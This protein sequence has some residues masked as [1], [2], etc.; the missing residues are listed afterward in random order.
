MKLSAEFILVKTKENVTKNNGI[1]M[2]LSAYILAKL[3]ATFQNIVILVNYNWIVTFLLSVVAFF[4][5]VYIMFLLLFMAVGLDTVSGI[6]ASIKQKRKITSFRLRDTAIKLFLY[7]GLVGLVY[8]IE[9]VCLWGI[10]ISNIVAAF[11]LFAEAVSVSEN[12]DVLS[13]GK[14]GIAAFVKKIREKWFTK[15]DNDL[16]K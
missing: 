6:F 5:P 1:N 13:N 4:Q 16:N 10:P 14:L 12:I 2:S 8:G 11:I 7:V 3:T 9:F 15:V